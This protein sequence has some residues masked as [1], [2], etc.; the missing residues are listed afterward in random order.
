MATIANTEVTTVVFLIA[1]R[2]TMPT[3]VMTELR[4]EPT[5]SS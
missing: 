2:F 1:I 3:V 4:K 5:S